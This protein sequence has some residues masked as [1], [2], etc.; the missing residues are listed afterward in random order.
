MTT[1][2]GTRIE[3]ARD[4]DRPVTVLLSD[5]HVK[6]EGG[7]A[8]ELLR[9][10]LQRAARRPLITRVL[11]LGDLFEFLTGP[12][13]LRV[14]AHREVVE[15]IRD[16]V[17]A[18]VS[19]TVLRGNRDYMMDRVFE[20]LSGARN[21]RHRCWRG[22][23]IARFRRRPYP[24][25]K[26]FRAGG[27]R[28]RCNCG[29]SAVVKISVSIEDHRANPGFL[30]HAGDRFANRCRGRLFAR[31]L[32][33]HSEA[34]SG[35]EGDLQIVVDQL[36]INMVGGA[37]HREPRLG[38][39]AD[40]TL[41]LALLT[42]RPHLPFRLFSHDPVLST[43]WRRPSRIDHRSSFLCLARLAFFAAHALASVA[44]PF[45]LVGL[46]RTE[47]ADLRCELTDALTIDTADRKAPQITGNINF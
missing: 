34:R 13:Q 44:Y 9:D 4:D 36:R 40:D 39:A 38:G 14:E 12:R 21:G 20:R 10:V 17:E 35:T 47:R 30:R 5:L 27:G 25:C 7:T 32:S 19:V 15:A 23:G 22:D 28:P 26:R 41:T 2:L 31:F 42:P 24:S 29:H 45:A 3:D 6:L 8:L 18:G 46:R 16:A 1:V 37:K 11:I 33:L 43:S